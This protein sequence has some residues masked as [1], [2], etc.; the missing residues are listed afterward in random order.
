MHVQLKFP[1]LSYLPIMSEDSVDRRNWFLYNTQGVQ[2]PQHVQYVRIDPTSVKQIPDGAFAFC[3]RLVQVQVLDHHHGSA[4]ELVLKIIGRRAFHQCIQLT[5]ASIPSSAQEIA[6]RAYEEC[7]SLQ[8]C[9]L[10]EQLKWIG[11]RAFRRC[12]SLQEI[13]I[14]PLVSE[15]SSFAF[16]SCLRLRSLT[17]PVGLKVIREHAFHSCVLLENLE[18][19]NTVE[20][21]GES[22]FER[23]KSIARLKI[24]LSTKRI[25]DAAFSQCSRLKTVE[26]PES[27]HGGLWISTKETFAH[28]TDLRNI[29]L[30]PLLDLVRQQSQESST[31]TRFKDCLLLHKALNSLQ[32]LDETMTVDDLL[33]RRFGMDGDDEDELFKMHKLCYYQSHYSTEEVVKRIEGMVQNV[34]QRCG[35]KDNDL[36]NTELMA[37]LS[38]P[39]SLEMTPMHI[40]V[41]SSVPRIDLL[42][43]IVKLV[44]QS[45][46]ILI[47]QKDAWG[48]TPLDCIKFQ[49]EL[50][51]FT[52]GV[53]WLAID[54]RIHFLAL[55]AWRQSVLL[56]FDEIDP[57]RPVQ[58]RRQIITLFQKLLQLE[59]AESL[60]IL[61]QALWKRTFMEI[62]TLQEKERVVVSD[63][64]RSV[65]NLLEESLSLRELSRLNCGV[66]IV[67]AN[68]M[69]FLGEV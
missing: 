34:R 33:A 68:I 66:D 10:P 44:P 11:K 28:C 4:K 30:S 64:T 29:A 9:F 58:R 35:G 52:M 56:L 20:E 60:C 8:E 63:T 65:A 42:A 50:F 47:D 1:S 19:P 15:I 43:T 36:A 67:T 12:E 32:F 37:M 53:L 13:S 23:C 46:N 7:Q 45:A 40:L 55:L 22:A 2:V 62:T 5:T 3:Q 17:L 27:Q 16:Q 61:E 26:M 57:E 21:I 24:P 54:R 39:D 49:N 14:P 38:R 48:M 51:D 41:M 6:D 31:T 18:I 59:R 25:G 69:P